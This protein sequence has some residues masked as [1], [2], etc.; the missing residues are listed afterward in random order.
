MVN[1]FV[2]LG[3]VAIIYRAR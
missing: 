3:K 1:K 2:F